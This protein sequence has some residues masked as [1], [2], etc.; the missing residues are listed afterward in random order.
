MNRQI[1]IG[2]AL[3]VGMGIG[4]GVVEGLH[5]QA[6]PPAY[7]IAENTV[8]N[9]DG[10]MK[11]FVPPVEKSVQEQGGKFLARGGRTVA[12]RGQAPAPRVVVIQFDNM[13]KAQAWM[14]SASN[15][16]AQ[17]IGDKYATFRGY[18]VEGGQ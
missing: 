14:N 4:A 9:Q 15:K 2:L 1:T 8:T 13:D 6:K 12:Y 17:A 7:F 3:A 16:A 18:A 5:A 11:E 10:Y